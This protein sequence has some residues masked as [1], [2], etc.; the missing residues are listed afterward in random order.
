M[1]QRTPSKCVRFT[2]RG[3]CLDVTPPIDRLLETI[4][5]V[6]DSV[7]RECFYGEGAGAWSSTA[8]KT[9]CSC[10]SGAAR[11]CC[12]CSSPRPRAPGATCRPRRH[13]P[14][15]RLLRGRRARSRRLA[16][17]PRGGRGRDRAGDE[18]AARR[19][20]V[21][22]PRPRRQ[23]PGARDAPDLGPARGPGATGWPSVWLRR[24]QR[25]RSS[26]RRAAGAKDDR[27][28][29]PRRSRSS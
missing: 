1:G 29:R 9:A 27:D 8:G 16:G 15:P 6:H 13:G 21:L 17:A 10:S 12:C 14:G 3:A 20:L 24:A 5:Y 23:Q 11:A 2:V 26:R 25:L 28:R 18:L 19:P 4:L 22:F 7:S